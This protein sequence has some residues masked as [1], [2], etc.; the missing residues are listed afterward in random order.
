MTEKNVQSPKDR[1]RETW[2]AA[3]EGLRRMG[4]TPAFFDE[5]AWS[6]SRLFGMATARTAKGA[7]Y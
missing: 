5:G 3:V 4:I 6:P 2:L 1:Q 7:E